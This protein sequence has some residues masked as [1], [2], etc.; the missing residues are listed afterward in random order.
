MANKKVI[1]LKVQVDTSDVDKNVKRTTETV[2][3]LGDTTKKTSNEMKAGF[4]AAE[5]GT[6]GLGSS[7]GGLIKALG[8]VGVAMA[9][10][11]FMKDILSKNQKVMDALSTATTAL[12]IIINKLFE[13]LEPL[14][15]VMKRAFEDPKGFSDSLGESIDGLIIRFRSLG[16]VVSA[17]G[18]IINGVL[19]FDWARAAAGTAKLALDW[20]EV[21]EVM[22]E[23]WESIKEGVVGF[24]ND[25]SSATQAAVDQ[26]KALV[27]LRN[28]VALLE[29]R[30]R[31]LILEYQNEAEIQR[32]IRDD[33]SLTIA[34]R[35]SAN[36]ELGR[37]LDEQ[38]EKEEAIA[39]KRLQLARAELALNSSSIELQVA[40]IDAETELADVRERINGQRSEQLTNQIAL[41]RELADLQKQIGLEKLEDQELEI[42][43]FLDHAEQMNELAR[44][45]GEGEIYTEEDINARLAA[46]QDKFLNKKLMAEQAAAAKAKA[47]AEA[48]T[49][50]RIA[51]AFKL[52][53]GISSIVSGLT[54]QS[55]AAVAIQKTIAIAQIAIDTAR[56]L[57]SAITAA[58]SAAAATGPGAVVAT[59]VF[60][61]T[62]IAT[63][64]AAV[65]QAIGVLNSA[66]G[67]GSASLPSVS[68][69]TAAAAPSFNP[70]TTNTTELG[71]AEAAELAPIQA[72]VVETQ[73]TGSQ[74]NVNQIEGQ[75]TF[76]GG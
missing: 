22:G 40:L 25:I 49:N 66:P 75:A 45:A 29:A 31:G 16:G 47:I 43:E 44:L 60:I 38:A 70:V 76:G 21:K 32:Q 59:P 42:Q 58:T 54:G 2:E 5:Q 8:I 35:L 11:N 24:V 9:V 69:P 71:N 51:L 62:Q 72:Y 61:A 73:L 46:I 28:E 23:T 6:K 3:E 39:Q 33:I 68:V 56:S 67:G 12:E 52:A 20:E 30:Q 10:F 4:K 55:K 19:S 1:A 17:T 27:N 41:E 15:G 7:I 34:E 65:G 50:E 63:V 18:D 37:I 64:L 13:S 74:N 14:A 53:N 36:E 26:A 48:E 57:S